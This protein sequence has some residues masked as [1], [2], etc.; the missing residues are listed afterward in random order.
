LTGPEPPSSGLPWSFRV[1]PFILVVVGLFMT[2]GLAGL[3]GPP[4]MPSDA[5]WWLGL[6][7]L[8]LAV[9]LLALAAA[10]AIDPRPVLLR[11]ALA[12]A[13]LVWLVL[14]GIT[15]VAGVAGGILD[16][17][18]WL[19]AIL[20]AACAGSMAGLAS[21]TDDV[22]GERRAPIWRFAAV[23]AFAVAILVA[24]AALVAIAGL[25]VAVWESITAGGTRERVPWLAFTIVLLIPIVTFSLTA[26][27]SRHAATG[28]FH[29]QAAANRRNG[30]LLLVAMIGVVAATSEVIAVSLTFDPVPAVWAAA[31]AT[32]VGVGTALLAGRFGSEIVLQS[33]GARPA[34]PEHDGVLLNV[35]E[36]LSVAAAIPPP[37]VYVIEDGSQNAFATGRDPEHASVAVTRGL[38]DRMDREQLQGVIA[39]ELG[40]VRNLDI[41]YALYVAIL[42]GMVAVVTDGFLRLVVE[43]WR[44]GAF[45]W[46]GS[47]KNAAGTLVT[48]LLVGLFLLIVAGLLRL[49]APLFSAL[50]QAATSREREFLA[51]ATSVEFT[52]NPRGLERAL[53]EIAA[54]TDTLESANR[55]TQHLWFRNP[56]K[57]GSDRR[58]GV[59]STHPSLGARIDRLRALRGLDPIDGESAAA[60]ET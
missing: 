15:I 38:L 29:A 41:R 21:T 42:V 45:V 57:A 53:A 26:L 13:A 35:V 51:D 4:A 1:P 58:V 10:V 50:V 30:L 37:R 48:G 9:S 3:L 52:R 14:L 44:Q 43:G 46:K 40:H 24:V 20:A 7:L 19:L 34:T 60:T 8:L 59:F 28:T 49:L 23:V 32:A 11:R 31:F 36:E 55:G 12:G 5:P 47:G 27:L 33:A 6:F 39:H 16:P 56:V 25:V 2:T 54:D 18:L 22:S 17:D